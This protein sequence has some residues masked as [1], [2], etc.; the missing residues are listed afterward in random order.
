MK[1]HFPSNA[2]PLV[3][4]DAHH[5]SAA[6]GWLMLGDHISANE[7]LEKLPPEL[8]VHPDVLQLRWSIY[9]KAR[10]WQACL[11]IGTAIL[12]MEPGSEVGWIR[13]A[14][15]FHGLKDYQSA[16]ASLAPALEK[17]PTSAF[18]KYDLACYH[19]L[20]GRMMEARDLLVNAFKIGGQTLKLHALNDPDLTVFWQKIGSL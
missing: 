10:Q 11:D 4:P 1:L 13:T 3:P 18:V 6:E 20:L 9:A 2:T 7:E 12:K 16:L 8:R 19:C 5:L 15:A 17:F 14:Q